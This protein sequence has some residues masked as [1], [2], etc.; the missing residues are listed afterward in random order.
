MLA[1]HITEALRSAFPEV[2][3]VLFSAPDPVATLDG[4]CADL[5]PLQIFD[6]GDEAIIYLGTVTHVHS[7]R[8]WEK[9]FL[10]GFNGWA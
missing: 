2:A 4:P 10:R 5:S 3:F 6:D 1:T 8:Y 9:V 7:P